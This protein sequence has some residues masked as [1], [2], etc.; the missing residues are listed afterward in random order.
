MSFL[1]WPLFLS[2]VHVFP[3]WLG[4]HPCDYCE[5]LQCTIHQMNGPVIPDNVARGR[6]F[7]ECCNGSHV[8]LSHSTL[9]TLCLTLAARTELWLVI[10]MIVM[11]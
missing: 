8:H 11:V 1:L 9:L 6:N 7:G 3:F 4:R 2:L 5:N 10:G